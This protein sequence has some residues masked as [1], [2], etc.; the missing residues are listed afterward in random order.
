MKLYVGTYAKYNNGSIGGA[1][2]DLDG[3]AGYDELVAACRQLHAD[4]SDPE[5]M[6]QDVER[7]GEDWQAGFTG[8]LLGGY[9][10]YWTVRD[11]FAEKSAK[12]EPIGTVT[13]NEERN[14]IEIRFARR[15]AASVLDALKS[16]GWR[17][18]RFGGCWY[19]RHSSE[20]EA[21]A[22]AI[23]QGGEIAASEGVTAKAAR[24]SWIR[25]MERDAK[26]SL[27]EY[28]AWLES[29]PQRVARL[30]KRDVAG[31]IRDLVAAVRLDNGSFV[32]VDKPRIETEFCCGEN[33][34]G[35]GGDGP[36][37][38][39]YASKACE[40]FKT[41]AGFKIRNNVKSAYNS[42]RS[43]DRFGCEGNW[44]R[45]NWRIVRRDNYV[46][47][48]LEQTNSY[49]CEHRPD[50]CREVSEREWREIRRMEAWRAL[51]T[52]RRVNAY[53]KRFGASKLRTWT[54][55]TEA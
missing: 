44:K 25:D 27:D 50:L 3:F 39:A 40:N 20:A 37:T 14:G 18:S 51:S 6:V 45:E 55:W 33:D 30:W 32:T 11:E 2:L 34:R 54:Y 31:H 46:S 26:K 28:R 1:W 22:A 12:P 10:D 29:D 36:G 4:E 13:R 19:T 41:E 43:L 23:T 16:N 8:E 15:P 48:Y 49:N 53:W 17:W 5:F 42:G 21:F 38:I 47:D 35:Q 9:S 24:P 7:D 52:R